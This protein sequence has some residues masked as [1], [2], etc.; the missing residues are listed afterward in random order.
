MSVSNRAITP[1]RTQAERREGAER[2]LLDAAA[3]LFAR[4]GIDNT[5]LAEIGEEAGYSRGLVNHHFGSKATLVERLAARAQRA[6]LETFHPRS[7][8][9][10]VHALFAIVD[11]YLDRV[12]EGTAGS[13]A[14]F[15]MWGAAFP[16]DSALRE[17]FTADDRRFRKGVEALVR[18]GQKARSIHAKV[19]PKGF[20]VAFVALMRG[21][22][23]QFCVDP[24]GVDL[25]AS[26][27]AAVAFIHGALSAAR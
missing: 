7:C 12:A 17:I 8:A 5:S 19:D 9:D 11:D 14:F 21:I 15:V 22:G 10:E 23:A 2:G 24:T 20:A 13:H 4:R 6:F 16:E 18:A 1:R 3:R 27:K 26:R 25:A